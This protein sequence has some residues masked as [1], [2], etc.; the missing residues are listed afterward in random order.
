MPSS[1][2]SGRRKRSPSRRH[3]A[4]PVRRVPHA[5]PQPELGGAARPGNDYDDALP[6]SLSFDVGDAPRAD[7]GEGGVDDWAGMDGDDTAVIEEP[8]GVGE[9][10]RR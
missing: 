6:A 2:R 3:P 8:A 5:R 7:P 4:E 1:I 10:R 9:R